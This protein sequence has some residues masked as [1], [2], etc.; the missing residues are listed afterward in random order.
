MKMVFSEN[1]VK[2]VHGEA[3]EVLRKLPENSIDAIVTDPPYGLEFMGKGWD[4]A[5]EFRRS[6]NAA[7]AGRESEFGRASRTS[8]EY[9]AGHLFQEWCEVWAREAFRILKPGGHMLAFGGTR[10]WHRLTAGVE[11]AGF[12]I[13]DSIAWLYGSG[14]PKS[15][16][17]SKAI[18]KAMG[19]ERA[20]TSRVRG[21]G[22]GSSAL[23]T[24]DNW[25]GIGAESYAKYDTPA[26]P[27]AER[28]QG[29]GTA[30][31]PAFEPIVVARK[32]L[33][34]GSTVTR[35]V[36][37]HGTGALN[38]DATRIK[39]GG[40]WP[41]NVVL[42]ETQAEALD[43][44]TGVTKS[45]VRP[46]TGKD[47]RGIANTDSR[48]TIRRNDTTE[49]GHADS[50]GASRFFKTIQNEEDTCVA[51]KETAPMMTAT[52]VASVTDAPSGLVSVAPDVGVSGDLV[53]GTRFLYTA[54]APT[55]ER[56]VVDGVA[57][58]TVKP[59]ALMEWLIKL[60]TPPGGIVLDPFAGSGTT[61]E[62][63]MRLG[64]NSIS[65]EMTEE[66][67]PLILARVERTN[68]DG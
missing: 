51:P 19:A 33:P 61:T 21:S 6:L 65:I 22:I 58:P 54:K 45:S 15:M 55:K 41:A 63:A 17:V 38:I 32:P 49:R 20:E 35:N 68:T 37:T 66:Y 40:R 60:V 62:A 12:E 11:D 10:T 27:D 28:W 25:K 48:V 14:F 26:T 31:K 67:I 4:G 9:R 57:H 1:G 50:G 7:D 46:P 44:Q 8:P 59:V 56:P 36:L 18:D 5:D 43:A 24:D 13:R 52:S 53:S 39:S 30:L 16:D 29:W 2:V 42:D 23:F 34:K 64:F 3:I 47:D